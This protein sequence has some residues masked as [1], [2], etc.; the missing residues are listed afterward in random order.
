MN[1]GEK[2]PQGSKVL[3]LCAR[4]KIR[5]LT[6]ERLFAGTQLYA[7][8]SRGV[9]ASARIV[10]SAGD[11]G[12]ADV[13]FVMEKNHKNLLLR[14]FAEAVGIRPVVCLFVKDIYTVGQ[15]ALVE[16]LRLVLEPY[17]LLPEARQGG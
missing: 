10:V 6:A 12:W 13:I 17:L 4:N 2:Y 15:P 16:R 5:S 8:R 14:T 7:V 11:V 3:F 1:N 9:A